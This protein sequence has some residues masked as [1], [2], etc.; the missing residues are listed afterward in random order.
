MVW[1]GAAGAVGDGGGA[2]CGEEEGDGYGAAQGEEGV[3]ARQGVLESEKREQGGG[4]VEGVEGSEQEAEEEEEDGLAPPGPLS[5]SS[6]H[7][8]LMVVCVRD[9]CVRVCGLVQRNCVR[10]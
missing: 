4:V 6:H 3:V 9:V 10:V 5:S 2:P 7:S 8:A 1:V